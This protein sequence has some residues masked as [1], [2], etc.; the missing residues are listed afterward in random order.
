MIFFDGIDIR[1]VA[2]VKVEDVKVSGIQLSPVTR[3]RAIDGGSVLVRNR[4]AGRTVV[5]TFALLSQDLNDRMAALDAIAEWAKTDKEYK[6]VLPGHLNRYLMAVCTE[7]PTP[8][9]RQWWE[10]KL[11]LVFSCFNDP[12]WIDETLKAVECGTNFT[13]RGDAPPIMQIERTL[14]SDASDQSYSL[15]GRTITFSTI[16][17]GDLVID[18]NKQTA[19][20]DGVSIMQH[21]NVNS[22]FLLPQTGFQACTGTGFVKYRERWQ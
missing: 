5:I 13:V 4:A 18:L 22:R 14:A 10:A 6:L 3:P 1:T 7:K 9:T 11:R 16:P 19:E 2:G 17:A 8:S 20:V 12:Y 21:Y 15:N